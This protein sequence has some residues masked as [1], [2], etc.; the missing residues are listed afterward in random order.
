MTEKSIRVNVP[1]TVKHVI[2]IFE[3]LVSKIYCFL[4]LYQIS[5]MDLFYIDN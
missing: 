2:L 1:V 4:S 3:S 5:Y